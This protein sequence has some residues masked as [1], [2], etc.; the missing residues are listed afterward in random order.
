MLKAMTACPTPRR[1]GT[2]ID[3]TWS[4]RAHDVRQQPWLAFD[5]A[6]T[7]A[8]SLLHAMQRAVSWG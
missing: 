2:C 6:V 1:Q 4:C 3:L 7:A 8:V 5:H